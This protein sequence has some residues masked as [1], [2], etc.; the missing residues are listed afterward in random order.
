MSPIRLRRLAA[1]TASLAV[2]AGALAFAAAPAQADPVAS[3]YGNGTAGVVQVISVNGACP[4]NQLSFSAT[5]SN[6]AVSTAAP[7]S[8]GADG[9][10][11]IYWTPSIAGT[12]T[13]A[14]IG[15]TCS[16]VTLGGASIAQ[17]STTTTFNAPN[18]A[19]VGQA[20]K[21]TVYVT[22]ANQSTYQP[23][24]TVIVRDGSGNQV[25][26]PMGLT[27]GP[28]QGQSYAYWWWT[29]PTQGTYVFQATYSGDA[30]ATTSQ[31]YADTI[32]ASSSGNTISLS[33]PATVTAGS[34]VTLTASLVP[35]SMQ[36]SVGFTYNGQPISASIPIVNGQ[37][38]MSWNPT[39]SGAGV[40]GA[41]YTTNGGATGSTTSKV[42]VNAGPT[43]SDLITLTQPGYGTWAPNG[44]Y[45][46]GKGSSFAFQASTL[47][48]A[49]VTLAVSGPCTVS[50][51]TLTVNGSGAAC[52][53]S[54]KSTGQNGYGPVTQ[55][56]TVNTTI[57]QQTA[58]VAAPPSGPVNLKKTII[59]EAPGQ[60]DTN[61]GQN[62]VWSVQKSSKKVCKLGFP[63]DGSVTVKLVK[64]GQCTVNGKAPGI[65]GQ[66]APFKV[67]RTYTA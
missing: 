48:G 59:L 55:N 27:A 62:I 33:A 11:T 36:G 58:T 37:A 35:S 63:S 50:G 1:G 12:V 31:S 34:P 30:N 42:T 25:G 17:V 52:N 18:V 47:S 26:S 54:A 64:R 44:T 65:P 3:G 28:G 8:S 39:G 7:V 29:P 9:S 19:K 14:M 2:V 53:L 10:A 46:L 5:Y 4:S 57:G 41:N 38:S 43:Q 6:G 66:W 61:A 23:T 16:P 60:A 49:P 20:T 13:S 40:L 56:Y 22:S 67:Q 15:S 51:L 45:N 32:N 24:G 21:V